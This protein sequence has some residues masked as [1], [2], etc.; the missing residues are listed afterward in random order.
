[1]A[2]R[3]RGGKSLQPSLLRS[4]VERDLHVGDLRVLSEF[5]F[6]RTRSPSI[7]IDRLSERGFLAK[8]E[9]GRTRM[10]LKGWIAVFLRHTFARRPNRNF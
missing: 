10:T 3:N 8:T 4:W 9:R 7:V 1:V 5:A 6:G 2:Q